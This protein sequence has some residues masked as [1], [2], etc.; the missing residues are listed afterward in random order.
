MTTL[1]N[2][3][4]VWQTERQTAKGTFT[5]CDAR[6]RVHLFCCTR[7]VGIFFATLHVLVKGVVTHLLQ[8]NS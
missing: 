7:N 3:A 8:W 1:K 2:I 6:Q 4:N 5:S